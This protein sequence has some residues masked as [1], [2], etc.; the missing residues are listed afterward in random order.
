V[1][2]LARLVLLVLAAALVVALIRDGPGGPTRWLKAKF[3]GET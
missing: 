2:S 3:L 1:E